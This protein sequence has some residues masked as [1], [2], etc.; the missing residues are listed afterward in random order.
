MP[1]ET[2]QKLALKQKV[3]GDTSVRPPPSPRSRRGLEPRPETFGFST[4]TSDISFHP[5]L[6]LLLLLTVTKKS[7]CFGSRLKPAPAP[8]G[9]WGGTNILDTLALY[10]FAE[11]SATLV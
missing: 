8:R 10:V 9:C 1:L 4:D 3:K 6:L 7:K 5:V 11:W 2:Y